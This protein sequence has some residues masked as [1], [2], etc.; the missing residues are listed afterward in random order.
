[1]ASSLLWGVH[2]TG[3]AGGAKENCPTPQNKLPKCFRQ[4]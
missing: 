4:R 1:M 2:L 3:S